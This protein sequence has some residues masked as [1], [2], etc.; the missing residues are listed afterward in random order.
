MKTFYLWCGLIYSGI[1]FA[2]PEVPLQKVNIDLHDQA[3]LQRGAQVFMNYCSG[4]HSIKY[5]RYN[6][7]AEDLGLLTFEGHVDTELLV[8]N[9]IFTS[10]KPEDPIQISMLPADARQWFGKV[11]PDLSLTARERGPSWIYTYL[12]SFYHDAKRPFGSN[13]WLFP[14]VAMPNVFAPLQGDVLYDNKNGQLI[15]YLGNGSMTRAQFESTLQDLVTFLTYV[16]EPAKLVRYRMGIKVLLFM[17]VLTGLAYALKRSY[18]KQL[19]TKTKIVL[20][21]NNQNKK[22]FS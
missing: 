20:P 7:M 18:W 3:A 14:D 5:M 15:T 16:G 11:P 8:N 6:K 19:R 10:A 2:S 21:K 9:L 12:Q 1:L 4:C 13:N 17:V 22:F